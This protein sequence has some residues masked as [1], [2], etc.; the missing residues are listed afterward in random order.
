[1]NQYLRINAKDNVAVALVPLHKGSLIHLED[2]SLILKE[3]I[4]QGHKF[5]LSPILKDRLSESLSLCLSGF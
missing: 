4:P 2:I 1:M 5:A 3:D